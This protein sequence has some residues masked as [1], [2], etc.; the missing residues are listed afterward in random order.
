MNPR[1]LRQHRAAAIAFHNAYAEY[2]KA[3]PEGDP[4]L[5]A[6]VVELMPAAHMALAR[7]GV[8]PYMHPPRA[9]GGPVISGLPNLAFAHEAAF[10]LGTDDSIRMVR[11]SLQLA[12][13]KLEDRAVEE[14]RRRRNPLYWIDRG[15]R[16]LLGV[17][18][19][20]ISLFFPHL[21]FRDVD[22]SAFGAPLRLLS[23]ASSALAIFWIGRQ[24][25]WW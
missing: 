21:S 12:A 8:E 13:A 18:A 11:D 5:R 16:M 3:G 6:R 19:Y 23:A 20:I 7:A 9:L 14:E 17:P 1:E 10:S 4:R 22:S 24:A 2:L 15:L 25:K